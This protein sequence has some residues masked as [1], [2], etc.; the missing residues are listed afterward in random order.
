MNK[1]ITMLTLVWC[2][3]ISLSSEAQTAI[4]SIFNQGGTQTRRLTEQI[5]LLKVYKGYLEKG[6]EIVKGG[7]NT[8]HSF[9]N[10]E[11]SLHDL[12][13]KSLKAVNPLIKKYARISDIAIMQVE[14]LKMYD[15]DYRKISASEWYN[16]QEQTY[17]NRVYTQIY[18][19][20]NQT[21]S[22]L[23]N[24]VN[25]GVWQMDDAQRIARIDKL[26]GEVQDLYAFSRSFI[27][28]ALQLGN[29]RERDQADLDKVSEWYQ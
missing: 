20:L 24:L 17:L 12:F 25:D 6:Y 5:A 9:K 1:M 16:E 22:D 7:M 28:E 13:F 11:F 14:I 19:D 23:I 4:G 8:I 2:M 26:Y 15:T 3:T 29:A 18:K 27:Q 10:G 21:V